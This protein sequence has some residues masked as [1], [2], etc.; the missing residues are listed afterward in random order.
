MVNPRAR[1]KTA[2][3][4]NISPATPGSF[5]RAREGAPKRIQTA[6]G[7]CVIRRTAPK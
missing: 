5:A 4:G 2:R 7:A 1:N 6:I 3:L